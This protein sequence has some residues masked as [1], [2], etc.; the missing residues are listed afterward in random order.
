MLWRYS[1]GEYELAGEMIT[2]AADSFL[3]GLH[4]RS[5]FDM[6]VLLVWL[7]MLPWPFL[8]SRPVMLS[9]AHWLPLTA[10][11]PRWSLWR[12][13]VFLL[14]STSYSTASLSSQQRGPMPESHPP[15][16]L[17]LPSKE[18][19]FATWRYKRSSVL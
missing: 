17:R 8:N 15:Y 9:L 18:Q 10:S 2:A 19:P 7:N 12:V 5:C 11:P 14:S 4:S 3:F 1:K 6:I 13:L 16:W